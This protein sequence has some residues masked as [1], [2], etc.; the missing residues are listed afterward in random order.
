MHGPYRLHADTGTELGHQYRTESER[1]EDTRFQQGDVRECTP[2]ACG[3]SCGD[4]YL[5]PHQE[6]SASAEGC[7]LH[8][9]LRDRSARCDLRLEVLHRPLASLREVSRHGPSHRTA[10]QSLL[11]FGTHG[12]SLLLGHLIEHHLP[13]V[14]CHRSIGFVGMWCGIFTHQSGSALPKRCTGRSRHRNRMRFPEHLHQPMAEQ[15]A[16]RVMEIHQRVL[17]K[18]P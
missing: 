17:P 8:R 3:G 16:V 1:L 6:G 13:Q 10:K 9:Y 5:C 12:C 11:P 4:G 7:C 18:S 14:V 2:P 15:G